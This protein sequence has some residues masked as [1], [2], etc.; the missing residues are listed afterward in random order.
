MTIPPPS[1]VSIVRARM[2][3]V[4]ASKSWRM[5]YLVSALVLNHQHLSEWQT[6]YAVCISQDFLR[7]LVI[8]IADVIERDEELERIFRV[9]LTSAALYL[10]LDLVLPLLSVARET[11]ELV[12]VCPEDR[13]V[14]LRFLVRK[15]RVD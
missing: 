6:Y 3:G 12:F 10:L 5:H 13:L 7:L 1:T 9:N 2:L 15:D 8:D 4:M 14:P 11:K